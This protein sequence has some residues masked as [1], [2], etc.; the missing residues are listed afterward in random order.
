MQRIA[1]ICVD[2]CCP[3][4]VQ[5]INRSFAFD[6]SPCNDHFNQH[7]DSGID[8]NILT[9]TKIKRAY[10]HTFPSLIGSYLIGRDVNCFYFL[11]PL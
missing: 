1:E 10:L 5:I 3:T 6:L 9:C 4:I 2:V 11:Q 7:I 8:G